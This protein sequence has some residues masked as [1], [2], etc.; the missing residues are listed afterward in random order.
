MEW[1][2]SRLLEAAHCSSQPQTMIRQE[3]TPSL[4]TGS[5]LYWLNVHNEM[6]RVHL[7]TWLVCVYTCILITLPLDSGRQLWFT[8]CTWWAVVLIDFTVHVWPA[9]TAHA[10]LRSSG[11]Q[12]WLVRKSRY[13]HVHSGQQWLF[14]DL[15]ARSAL[16]QC[17][18]DWLVIPCVVHVFA[19]VYHCRLMFVWVAHLL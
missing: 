19:C 11:G 2:L 13:G 10:S 9:C 12:Y 16:T 1:E 5:Y 3:Y 18:S 14:I 17:L 15:T 8:F 6:L 7:C 4:M